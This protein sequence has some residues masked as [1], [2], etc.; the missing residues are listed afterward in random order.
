MAA[1]M[2][3]FFRSSASRSRSRDRRSAA[4]IG[5]GILDFETSRVSAT[6]V[7]RLTRCPTEMK[8]GLAEVAACA[9]RVNK[10]AV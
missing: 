10:P 2:A 9:A 1:S 4:R 7:S 5:S 6:A 8:T 3:C